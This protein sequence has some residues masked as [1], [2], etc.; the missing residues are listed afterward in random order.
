MK[1]FDMPPV[2]FLYLNK[3][4]YIIKIGWQQGWVI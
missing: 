1:N 4:D 3:E 2:T